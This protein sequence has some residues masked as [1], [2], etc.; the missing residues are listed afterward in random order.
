MG[1]PINTVYDENAPFIH[2]SGSIFYFSSTGHNTMGGY[3]IF[4]VFLG[5]SDVLM[6][7]NLGFPINTTGDDTY[8]TLS[9]NGKVGYFSSSYGNKYKNYDIY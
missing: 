2:P 6:P 4:S 5:D 3:D 1:E 9:A 8:F 7:E